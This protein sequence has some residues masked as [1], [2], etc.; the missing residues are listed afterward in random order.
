MR[1]PRPSTDLSPTA[2]LR[3][4]ARVLPVSDETPSFGPEKHFR[5]SSPRLFDSMRGEIPESGAWGYRFRKSYL[6]G[7]DTTPK[8]PTPSDGATVADVRSGRGQGARPPQR[9]AGSR[10]HR[11]RSS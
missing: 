3:P 4:A 11:P 10:P 2:R 6:L 5:T 7:S 9:R 8:F 1:A